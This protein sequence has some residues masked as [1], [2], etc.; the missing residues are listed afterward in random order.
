MNLNNL[1][2][3]ELK[4]AFDALEDAFTALKIDF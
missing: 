1:R 4:L 3:G 2:Q